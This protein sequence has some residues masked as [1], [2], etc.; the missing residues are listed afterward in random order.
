MTIGDTRVTL[1]DETRWPS[2]WGVGQEPVRLPS[3]L[4]TAQPREDDWRNDAACAS[5][6]TDLFFPNGSTGPAARQ[7]REAKNVC[8][9][10]SV[11]D[12][13]LNFALDTGQTY[14]VWGGL[15]EDER[16]AYQRRH[17]RAVETEETV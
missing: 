5:N 10:C 9:R 8:A 15:S 1:R 13:C 6:E 16:R 14:G 2:M 4:T 3:L 12:A 17:G 11:R 7:T